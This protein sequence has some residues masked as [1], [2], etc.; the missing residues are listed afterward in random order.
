MHKIVSDILGKSLPTYPALYL[1]GY[2]P[3]LH[4]SYQQK[5]MLMAASTATKKSI[6]KNWFDPAI[7]VKTLST[8]Y[9]TDIFFLEKSTAIIRNATSKSI[10]TWSKAIERLH[11]I[12]ISPLS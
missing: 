6:I 10:L 11:S 9:F 4:M 1:L 2:N 5:R 7:P 3:N 12:N 8:N